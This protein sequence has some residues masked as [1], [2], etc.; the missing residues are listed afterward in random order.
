MSSSFSKVTVVP[1]GTVSV[2][3]AKVK[4]PIFTM[5]SAANAAPPQA[6]RISA[7]AANVDRRRR[8]V[9]IVD[10]IALLSLKDET[11][12]GSGDGRV[13]DGE[14]PVAGA[15]LDAGNAEDAAK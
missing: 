4:L 1:A 6:D 11:G 3:G 8:V 15:H 7:L 12:I 9:E 14:L 13:G 2:C 10:S 5:L